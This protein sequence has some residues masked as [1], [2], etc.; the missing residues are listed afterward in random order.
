MMSAILL[1]WLRGRSFRLGWSMLEPVKLGDGYVLQK[2]PSSDVMEQV[3]RLRVLAWSTQGRL[4]DGIER[5]TDAFDSL[6]TH[7]VILHQDQAV[8]AIRLSLHSSIGELPSSHVYLGVLPETLSPPIASY[9][10]LVVHPDHRGR[11]LAKALDVVCINAA[12]AAQA[13]VLVGFSGG[14]PCN[15]SRIPAMISLGF[16]EIGQGAA[17]GIDDIIEGSGLPMIMACFFRRHQNA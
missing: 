9:N 10:R 14:V 3:Y 2:N 12:E 6:A 8:A 15:R 17:P 11:N 5:W 1:S 7:W 16:I 4:R 13:T